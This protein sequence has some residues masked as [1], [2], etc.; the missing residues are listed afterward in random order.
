[1]WSRLLVTRKLSTGLRPMATSGEAAIEK[2]L[3]ERFK[4]ARSV[5]VSDVSGGC[6]AMY[7]IDIESEDFR[8]MSVLAQHRAVKEALR[9][10]I[11]EMHGLTISTKV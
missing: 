7:Q 2:I 3:K 8:G 11:K 9:E 6:G 5:S 10:Q 4:Q 1:M